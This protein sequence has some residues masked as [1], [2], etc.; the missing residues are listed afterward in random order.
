MTSRAEYRLLLRHDN[1]GSSSNRS[2]TPN[3]LSGRATIPSLSNEKTAVEEE[4][5]RLK[6]VRI[7]PTPSVQTFLKEKGTAPLKDG[8]LANEFLRRPEVNYQELF[9]VYRSKPCI[10]AEGN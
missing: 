5:Q 2:R 10:K 1:A 7:K 8:V 4:I 9:A 3:W 6:K